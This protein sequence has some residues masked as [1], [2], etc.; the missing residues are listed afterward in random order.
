MNLSS[1]VLAQKVDPDRIP[2]ITL[3]SLYPKQVWYFM[4]TFIALVSA[5]HAISALYAYATRKHDP[6]QTNAPLRHAVSWTRLPL[7]LLNLFRTLAFRCSIV[8]GSYT[9]NVADFVLV[10]GY[11][12]VLFT[13][14][15]IN[16]K[17][18]L[19]VK[20]DPKYWA[21]RCAHIAG[22]QLPLMTALG[23]KN[24]FISFLT[25]VSF[26]KL[27]YLHRLSARVIAVMFWVHAFGRVALGLDS[28]IEATAYWFRIGVT[29]ASALT[30]LCF[31]SIRPIRF[32]NYEFFMYVHLVLGVIALAGA[33]IHS[34]NFGYEVYIWPALFLWGLDRFFRLLRISFLNSQLFTP[35]RRRIAS[36]ATV[37]VLSPPHFLRILAEAP[38]YFTWRPGQSAYLTIRGAYP[39]SITEAH[40]FTIANAPHYAQDQDDL[41]NE[42]GSP[43]ES[44]KESG[45][46]ESEGKIS[47]TS[48]LMFILRVRDGFTK[49]LLDSVLA[50]PDSESS[51]DGGVSR[52]F[53]AFVDGPY[54]SPPVVRG[55][56][57]VVFIS[58]GSGVSFG[59]P[60][61]LDLVQA[62]RVSANPC[63]QRIV[64]VWAIRDSDQINWIAEPVTRALSSI[65]S[66]Q[67]APD[68][69]IR[70]HV[71]TAPEDTQSFDG[72][73]RASRTDSDAEVAPGAVVGTD[74]ARA[75]KI[76]PTTK[77]IDPTAKA[78]VRM[79]GMKGVNLVYG[80][81]D[82]QGILGA[83]IARAN[84]AVSVNVCGT[85]ELAQ[86]A[87]RALS[88]GIGG[89]FM[90]VLRGGPSVLLHVEGFGNS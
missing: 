54:S 13:W 64:F 65:S 75:E 79:L 7:A 61:L 5:C 6:P 40:P 60:L 34:A 20:Y 69:E 52:S 82:I 81:P 88:S 76:G 89:R 2:R 15:F 24:N 19:G 45:S 77:K 33:Y 49:R 29:G 55:F 23:M 84:G 1:S 11:I 32:R 35:R 58:G 48:R 14:T 16:S 21:N 31:L 27:E 80:R 28:D 47:D 39:T 8:A 38:R 41:P 83:E 37:T 63:C 62:A 10:A 56:E 26:D 50:N 90:D 87:R 30:L 9:L 72:E 17:N 51:G 36:H 78:K 18:T 43:N 57:T 22:S 85:T 25:G 59:L 74:V 3:A 71:T 46:A 73:D 67:G 4:A 44:E 68:V 42:D 66:I 12:A 70:L 53:E 86:S